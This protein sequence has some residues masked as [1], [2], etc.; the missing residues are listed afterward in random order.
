MESNSYHKVEQ[1]YTLYEQ[2]MYVIAYSI[3]NNSWQAE[4]AV[5]DA[6]VKIIKNLHKIKDIKSDKTK[7]FIIRIIQNTAIDLY[8]KNQRESIVF[9][10][11]SD[12][13]QS[14]IADKDNSIESMLQSM[15]GREQINKM[16][17]K[18]PEKYRE[19]L[20]YRSVHE[21]S[22][23][24]TAAVLEISENLVR[25]RYERARNLLMRELGDDEYEYKVI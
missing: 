12:E 14:N 19:V 10:I 1:L 5:S 6:F 18:I 25:K 9:T 4:D 8:R 13:E 7:K 2:K 23:K 22:V 17:S 15:E 20:L 16:L 3:L 21:F 24:E 11:V